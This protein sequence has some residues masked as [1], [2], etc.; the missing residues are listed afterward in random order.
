MTEYFSS[1]GDI[2]STQLPGPYDTPFQI[3]HRTD[4]GG[5]CTIYVWPTTDQGAPVG[6]MT[7]FQL[8]LAVLRND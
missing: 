1:T 5:Y 3:V 6:S 7:L 4:A 8:D 2:E